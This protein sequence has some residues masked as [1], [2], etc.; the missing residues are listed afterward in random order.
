MSLPDL[1]QWIENSKRSGTLVLSQHASHKKFYFQNGEMIF[2]WSDKEGERFWSYIENETRQSAIGLKEKF[3]DSEKLDIPILSYLLNERLVNKDRLEFIL[4]VILKTALTDALA[5]ETGIFEFVDSLPAEVINGPIKI[6][7]SRILMDSILQFDETDQISRVSTNHVLNE[8]MDQIR[9]GITL[10]PPLPDIMKRILEKIN[11]KNATVAEVVEN[12]TDQLLIAKILK[13]C[14]S[15][16][17]SRGIKI[18]SL[19]KA[20]TYLGFK[21]LLSIV[22]IHSISSFSPKNVDDIRKI[23]HHSLICGMIAKE[24]AESVGESRDTAFLCGV[25]HDLGKTILTDI[26]G[27]YNITAE[28]KRAII[29]ENHTETGYLLAK[30][31][32]FSDEIQE[33][34][35]WHHNPE[36]ADINVQLVTLIHLADMIAHS[37][38]AMD[39]I[40]PACSALGLSQDEVMSVVNHL[41]RLTRDV[42]NIL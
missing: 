12:I 36:K 14:N 20:I 3:K 4:T 5:W 22:T 15:P 1:I 18:N 8:I 38:R 11:D 39:G 40:G 25:L 28:A 21:S 2:V 34:V 30:E 6:N 32:G 41:D 42:A 17:F 13:I 33:A 24:L 26:A 23:L 19:H 27:A 35:H 37:G 31:W 9:N 16:Y 29:R 10:L 7:S